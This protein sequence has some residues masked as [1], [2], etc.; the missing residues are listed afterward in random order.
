ML[1]TDAAIVSCCPLVHKWLDGIQKGMAVGLCR[2]VQ[3][4]V[5]ISWNKTLHRWVCKK[6]SIAL[7]W[8]TIA[9]IFQAVRHHPV[10]PSTQTTVPLL[11]SK[12]SLQRGE[13]NCPSTNIRPLCAQTTQ[14]GSLFFHAFS[15][16]FEEA[17]QVKQLSNSHSCNSQIQRTVLH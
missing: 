11:L 9:A 2:D 13:V 14:I 12:L 3:V 5:S 4:Q 8:R 10:H 15:T 17:F 6:K 1:C 7:Q 16:T